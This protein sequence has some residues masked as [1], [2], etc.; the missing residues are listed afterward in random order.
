MFGT[1]YPPLLVAVLLLI[2][3]LII[4]AISEVF[5]AIREIALN[6][7]QALPEGLRA[8]L[9][10]Y[11]FLRAVIF[12]NDIIGGLLIMGAGFVAYQALRG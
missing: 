11:S 10:Q 1:Q 7:R 2:L 6:T 12:L 9:P 8:S 5:L 3:G 4:I